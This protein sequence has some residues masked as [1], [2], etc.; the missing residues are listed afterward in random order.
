MYLVEIDNH[1]G[2]VKVDGEF[3]G[4]RSIKEFRDIL[5]D[6]SLGLKCLTAIAL[7]A[8]FLT[9]I[10]YY[11]EEDRPFKAMEIATKGNRR[12]FDWAQDKI[13]KCL[14][15]YNELQYNPTIE[16]KKALD[17]MLLSKLDEI[18]NVSKNFH[19]FI[20][21][22]EVTFRNIDEVLLENKDALNILK[23]KAWSEFSVI[24][25]SVVIKKINQRVIVPFNERGRENSS[26][27]QE[28]KKIELFKQLG[29]IKELIE[30]FNKLNKDKD[31]FSDGPVRNG[32]KLSR[33]EE[34]A[35]DKNSFYHKH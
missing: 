7:V 15:R 29:T 20:P 2:L 5:N 16:E 13:Q 28:K 14:I 25:Q 23:D 26:I 33:L 35:L 1:T 3:D 6:E 12:A 11:T 22:E 9:P 18:K 30:S 17:E 10:K 24:D 19:T 21:L 4:V 27:R 34:K 8:D 31:V 32:Y